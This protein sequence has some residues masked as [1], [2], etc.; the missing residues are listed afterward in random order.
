MIR[1]VYLAATVIFVDI[2]F[3]IAFPSF[4]YWEEADALLMQKY[5]NQT[6][7]NLGGS[8][9]WSCHGNSRSSTKRQTKKR[10]YLV[11]PENKTVYITKIN[12]KPA[13]MKVEDGGLFDHVIRVVIMIIFYCGLLYYV[14]RKHF[15][16]KQF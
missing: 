6:Y 7:L 13:V 5:P 3:R 14:V 9:V 16:H 12:D 15:Q 1:L 4:F 8:D 10:E 11:Y 2:V